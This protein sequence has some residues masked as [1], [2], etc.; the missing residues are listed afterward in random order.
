MITVKSKIMLFLISL[1]Q[2]WYDQMTLADEEFLNVIK[3]SGFSHRQNTIEFRDDD[4]D[5]EE[6]EDDFLV[7]EN[8]LV[9]EPEMDA[10]GEAVGGGTLASA[11]L[12]IIKG[13]FLSF[14]HDLLCSGNDVHE[15]K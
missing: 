1:C 12:G 6:A 15:T 10:H 14:F 2:L 4:D 13:G 8:T 11:T 7:E 9:G 5:E 3:Y